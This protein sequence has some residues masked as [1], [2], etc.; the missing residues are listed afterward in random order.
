[1]HCFVVLSFALHCIALR[2]HAFGRKNTPNWGRAGFICS[3]NHFGH[4]PNDFKNGPSDFT[5]IVDPVGLLK[6]SGSNMFVK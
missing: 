1:M 4:A 6:A 5:T 2:V 3:R